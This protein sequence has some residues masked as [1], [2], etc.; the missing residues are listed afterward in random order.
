VGD[1]TIKTIGTTEESEEWL[2][3]HHYKNRSGRSEKE[4]EW[5]QGHH[6]KNRSRGLE[7]DLEGSGRRRAR[8]RKDEMVEVEVDDTTVVK[9]VRTEKL[10]SEV[11]DTTGA[12]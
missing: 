9:T 6:Y 10:E 12:R 1:T 2:Q 8:Q 3:G 4:E 11:D 7:V 5:L